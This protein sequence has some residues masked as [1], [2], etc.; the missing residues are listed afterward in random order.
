[1]EH[2]KL[3]HPMVTT[4]K[5]V[6]EQVKEIV[7]LEAEGPFVLKARQV[8]GTVLGTSEAIVLGMLSPAVAKLAMEAE[9]KHRKFDPTPEITL[10]C[11]S[12]LQWEDFDWVIM[13]ARRDAPNRRGKGT[14][15]M[16]HKRNRFH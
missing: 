4:I 15:K 3:E 5:R 14:R 7:P 11:A 13:R 12:P 1:M 9:V 10:Y 6:N 16:R 8:A 2:S